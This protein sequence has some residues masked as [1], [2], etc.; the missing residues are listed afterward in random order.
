LGFASG[1]MLRSYELGG[2]AARSIVP[3]RLVLRPE[4]GLH[5]AAWARAE[6][7]E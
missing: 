7:I 6:A 1:G 3:L 5:S 4:P 2:I